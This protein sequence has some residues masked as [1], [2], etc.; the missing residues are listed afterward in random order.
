MSKSAGRSAAVTIDT[1]SEHSLA[2]YSREPFLVW[3][4]SAEVIFQ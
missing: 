3:D 4:I 1:A 2:G